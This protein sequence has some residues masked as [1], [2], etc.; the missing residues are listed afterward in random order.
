MQGQARHAMADTGADVQVQAAIRTSMYV[1][2]GVQG[3]DGGCEG[4]QECDRKHVL[5]AVDLCL[6]VP[7]MPYEL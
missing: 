3:A 2:K 7:Q 4:E 5:V 6:A 1:L